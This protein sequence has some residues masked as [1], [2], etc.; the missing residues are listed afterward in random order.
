MGLRDLVSYYTKHNEANGEHNRDGESHN[1]SWNCGIEGNTSN[2]DVIQLRERQMK[3]FMTAL[4]I[5]QGV[6][7]ITMGDEYGH[8]KNGNNNTYCHDSDIN[9]FDWDTARGK[10]TRGLS[11]AAFLRF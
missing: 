7:M 5:S 6:P 4:I 2:Q 10:G 3:N 9:W 1:N 8:S 11:G